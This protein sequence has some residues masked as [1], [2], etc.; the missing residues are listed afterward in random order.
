[1][2]VDSVKRALLECIAQTKKELVWGGTGTDIA[3]FQQLSRK[4]L[5]KQEFWCL[6]QAFLRCDLLPEK[7]IGNRNGKQSAQAGLSE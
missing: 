7:Y 5:L 2:A 3:L 6:K 1:M 4:T